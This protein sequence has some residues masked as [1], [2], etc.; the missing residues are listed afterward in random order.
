MAELKNKAQQTILDSIDSIIQALQAFDGKSITGNKKRIMDSINAICPELYASIDKD[1][2]HTTLKIHLYPKERS[3]KLENSD[4]CC[5]YIKSDFIVLWESFRDNI[6]DFNTIKIR[7]EQTRRQ[8]ET[9]S[10]RTSATAENIEDIAKQAEQLRHAL[11]RLQYDS[12]T[13]LTEAFNIR[14]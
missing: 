4:Y 10:D 7:M 11:Q 13:E 2:W 1:A 5:H 3:F 6:L 12:D 14:F 8:Y 9:Y